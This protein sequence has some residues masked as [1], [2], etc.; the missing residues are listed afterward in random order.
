[1]SRNLFVIEDV[2]SGLWCNGQRFASFLAGNDYALFV[3]AKN[4]EKAIKA[5]ERR[6]KNVKNWAGAFYTVFEDGVHVA[7]APNQEILDKA[8]Q[9]VDEMIVKTKGDAYWSPYYA[10]ARLRYENM[11]VRTPDL[12]VVE[13]MPVKVEI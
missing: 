5:I 4:A 2:A 6:Y 9:W 8:F 13:I 11:K 12:R 10:K 7:Y 1:M 3:S